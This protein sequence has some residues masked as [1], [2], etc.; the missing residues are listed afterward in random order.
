MDILHTFEQRMTKEGKSANTI[1]NYT[2]DIR[3]IIAYFEGVHQGAGGTKIPQKANSEYVHQNEMLGHEEDESDTDTAS[4]IKW[5]EITSQDIRKYMTDMQADGLSASTINRRLQSARTFFVFLLKEGI[6]EDSPA[7]GVKS[8]KIANQNQT[9]WLDKH[10]VKLMFRKIDEIPFEKKR[11]LYR[12]IFST[13]V[14]SGLRAQEL[15]DLKMDQVDWDKG[16]LSVY[17]KGGKF[18]RVPFNK[19]T[20]R[21]VQEWLQ[22]RTDSGDYVF[23]SERSDQMSVR[24][25]EH[26][27]KKLSQ[28]LP[29]TFTVSQLRHTALKHIAETTGRIEI[30]ASIAGHESVE[31]SRR[32]IES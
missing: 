25:L 10:Q 24:A 16:L 8:K 19:A 15:S 9:K 14:N 7:E 18:R 1:R 23:Q 21:N 4:E 17:G 28:E 3:K 6:V 13:L 22:Y 32:Y 2:A 11:T 26:M 31:T 12:A 29:F 20:R 27:T 30:V 5:T